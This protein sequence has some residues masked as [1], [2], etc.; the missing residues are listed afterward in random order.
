LQSAAWGAV[1]GALRGDAGDSV[2]AMFVDAGDEPVEAVL[3]LA[4]AGTTTRLGN[5]PALAVRASHERVPLEGGA[6]AGVIRFNY[7]FP[8]IAAELDRAVD[9]LRDV[10]GIVIDLRGNPGGVGF[11]APGF[12]GHFLERGDTLGT[13]TTR[14]GKLHFAANP[15]RV[16]TQARPVRPFAGPVA[17]LTDALTASTSEIFAGGLQKLGRAR[18]FGETSAG[19][20]LPAYARRLP[21]GDVMMHAVADLTGPGGERF[22]GAGVT[23]DVVAPPTREALL[24]GGDPALDAALHWIRE[25]R[26]R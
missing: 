1:S 14:Q 2:G 12:A 5:L 4:P 8:V 9:A 15:R 19:Q 16:D 24:A 25:V 26:S 3:V 13:M 7:W 23:P 6:V 21:D 18:V 17:I 11:M 22:E 10:D 20:A